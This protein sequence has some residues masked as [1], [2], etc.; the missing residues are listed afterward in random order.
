[1]AVVLAATGLFLYLRLRA[2]L[3]HTLAQGLRTRAEDIAA[4]VQQSDTGLRDATRASGS[5]QTGQD[6]A[7]FAQVL[8]ASGTV[9]DGTTGLQRRPLLSAGQLQQ[10]KRG[11]STFDLSSGAPGPRPARL[12]ATPVHAQGRSLVV[13][14]GASL[15]DRNQA[16]GNLT[17]LLLL[18]GPAALLLA[19]LAAYGVATAALR[20]VESMRARAATISTDDLDQ[21]LPLSSSRDELFRLGETLNEMLARLEAGM[22]RERAFA[23]DASHE[24]RTPLAMLKTELELIARDR[25]GGKE[26]DDA[27]TAALGDTSRLARLAD[28]LLVLARAENDRM[29]LELRQVRVADLVAG[30]VRR[31]SDRAVRADPVAPT[32]CSPDLELRADPMRL[33]QALDNMVEN[34]L[35]HGAAPVRIEALQRDQWV[36]LHVADAGPGFPPGFLP[37]AFERFARGDAGHTT[38]GAG[39]GLAIVQAIAEAHGGSAHAANRPEGGADV[40]IAIP[41]LGGRDVVVAAEDGARVVA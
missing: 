20:P 12:L 11:S 37:H 39:L 1:M 14:V 4:L 36:E 13:V 38:S 21:R 9:F 25:P 6:G 3:D 10:A 16:L 29:A 40:W 32:L 2:D 33:E 7:D 17:T 35:R 34:A 19:A 22:A 30:I 41:T 23:A 28:D 8:D 27:L 18:G 26:L 15:A 31:H 5:S 24:L